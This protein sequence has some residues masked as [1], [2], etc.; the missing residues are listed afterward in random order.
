MNGTGAEKL[1]Y[2]YNYQDN[3]KYSPSCSPDSYGYSS[4]TD[5]S[6]GEID[7]PNGR[8]RVRFAT[9]TRN[10]KDTAWTNQHYYIMFQANILTDIYIEQDANGDGTFKTI[11]R[12]YHLTYET[13]PNKMIFPGVTWPAGGKP[14]R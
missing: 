1:T 12:Q 2:K 3:F 4:I 7:Y 13:D 11:V 9:T 5:V 6:L 10:D 14:R 8:Y